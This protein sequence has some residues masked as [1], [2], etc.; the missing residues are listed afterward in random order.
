[1]DMKFFKNNKGVI[2]FYLMISLFTIILIQNAKVD[3]HQNENG[4]V[5]VDKKM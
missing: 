3:Y 2:I 1:M 5:M 4:Y